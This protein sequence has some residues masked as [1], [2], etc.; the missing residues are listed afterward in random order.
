MMVPI[1]A[2]VLASGGSAAVIHFH[3][4]GGCFAQSFYLAKPNND[5]VPTQDALGRQFNDFAA[6]LRSWVTSRQLIPKKA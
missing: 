3:G 2:G 4:L 1:N 6:A 5:L